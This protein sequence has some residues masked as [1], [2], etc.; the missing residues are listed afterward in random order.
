[1]KWVDKW[2]KSQWVPQRLGAF[3]WILNSSHYKTA[4]P[5]FGIYP[6]N[7][8]SISETNDLSWAHPQ[9]PQAPTNFTNPL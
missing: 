3:L 7:S 9:Y 8:P 4:S 6:K 5:L 1:M 2:A